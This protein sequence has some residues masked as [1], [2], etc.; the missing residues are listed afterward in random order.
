MTEPPPPPRLVTGRVSA[1]RP[2]FPGADSAG[3]AEP[4]PPTQSGRR[5]RRSEKFSRPSGPQCRP[6]PYRGPVSRQGRLA[7]HSDSAIPVF[8]A[9]EER[10][11]R[12]ALPPRLAA[13]VQTVYSPEYDGRRD[14]YRKRG[15]RSH[16]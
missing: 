12:A 5:D 1:P 14:V 15:D 7:I 6:V 4:S 13:G 9:L 8:T 16:K 3:A 10:I 11:R 2:P